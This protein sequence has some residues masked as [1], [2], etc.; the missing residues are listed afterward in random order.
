MSSLS[1]MRMLLLWAQSPVAVQFIEPV[2]TALGVPAL[3][4]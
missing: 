2:R 4:T 1:M 3:F